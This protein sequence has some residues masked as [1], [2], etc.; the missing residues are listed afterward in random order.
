MPDAEYLCTPVAKM[1]ETIKWVYNRSLIQELPD[2][3]FGL[4]EYDDRVI[5]MGAFEL[6]AIHQMITYFV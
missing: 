2:H 3:P 1:Q 5:M 6:R 4:S